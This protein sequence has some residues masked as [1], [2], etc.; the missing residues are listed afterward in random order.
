MELVTNP[1][2]ID[3][4]DYKYGAAGDHIV[5]LQESLVFAG[6]ELKIDG[7]F[8]PETKRVIEQFETDHA[9]GNTLS[10]A[11]DI[12]SLTILF[13]QVRIEPGPIPPTPPPASR[14]PEGKG[15]FIR[16]LLGTGTV[17][18][19][20]EYIVERGIQWI[21]VQRI[22]QYPDNSKLYNA[23]QWELY[24][25]AWEETGCD[26]WIWGWAIPG[27]TDEYLEVMST[28][29]ADWSAVGIIIDAE[30]PWYDEAGEATLLMD[31]MLATG[32]PIG[33]TSYGAPWFHAPFPFEEFS[34]ASFGAPQIYDSDNSM[35]D[36]YPTRSVDTWLGFGY[37][38]V[39]PASAAYGKTG[40]QM[41]ELLSRTPTPDDAIMWWDW[42]NANADP[43][44]W[45]AIGEYV[46]P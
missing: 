23:A 22:W 34:R 32:L 38:H 13:N 11:V 30:A 44:R 1:F 42:Y 41:A 28:T 3:P 45:D 16:S 24:R 40:T 8:G 5:S 14:V 9:H 36:D 33:V 10:F 19:M 26:L 21:A 37:V 43:G 6:Y 46:L 12:R 15:M 7:D 29:A 39:V 20:K 35:S 4:K 31:K 25:E 2:D 27:K 18:N 17:E